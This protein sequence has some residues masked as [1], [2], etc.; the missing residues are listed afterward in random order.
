MNVER[1]EAIL[2]GELRAA[3]KLSTL[4]YHH[5]RL[6]TLAFSLRGR[7]LAELFTD[8]VTGE[9]SYASVTGAVPAWLRWG[10]RLAL[11]SLDDPRC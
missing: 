1:L 8:V 5:P 10:A 2:L 6:R 7:A 3:S 4:L 11:R 9:R